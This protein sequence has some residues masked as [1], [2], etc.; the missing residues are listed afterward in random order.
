MMAV[1]AIV[2]IVAAVTEE[3]VVLTGNGCPPGT[4]SWHTVGIDYAAG[5]GR[6]RNEGRRRASR[7][8]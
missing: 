8:G 1:L 7:A 3:D 2:T 4:D 5:D 6:L